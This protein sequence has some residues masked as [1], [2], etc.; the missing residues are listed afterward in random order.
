MISETHVY[1]LRHTNSRDKAKVVV[2]KPLSAIAKI[3]CKKKYPQII[4]FKYGS[5]QGDNLVI[6]DMDR[7]RTIDNLIV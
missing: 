1:V 3:T 6:N 5:A 4:T 2:R 7:Y